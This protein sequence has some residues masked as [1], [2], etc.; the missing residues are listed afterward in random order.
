MANSLTA[1]SPDY[2]S[3]RMQIVRIKEP[4][5]KAIANT[6]ERASLKNGDVVHRPYRSALNVQT[7]TKGTAVTVQDLT[8]TDESLTVGTAKIVPFYV[9]DL[10]Q[11]QNKWDTVNAFADDAGRELEA[12]I[13]GDFLA[14]VAN[15]TGTVT[16]GDLGG[17]AGTAIVLS[18]S[19]V[20]KVFAAAGKKLTNQLKG[21]KMGMTDRFAVIT[22]TVHQ[23]LVEYLAGKDTNLADTIGQNGKIGSFLGF[24]LYLSVNTYYTARWTPADMPSDGDT[25]TIN[26]VVLTFETGTVDTAGKVKSETSTA[27]TLDNLVTALSAPGTSVSG[28]Y[29][30]VSAAN[31]KLLQGLTITDGT[32]YVD[33]AVEGGG[34]I[35]VAA[36][37]AA[38]L[39]SLTKAHLMFGKKKC[40][41]IVVQK[42]PSVVFKEVPDKLGKNVLPWTLYGLKTFTEG[43]QMMVD[44]V[45]DASQF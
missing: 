30:A 43:A 35:A 14:E 20:L 5:Y 17:T 6:E 13:D 39:W 11:L 31:Q 42:E 32:T 4:V 26:G 36:S 9:D 12:F 28:V 2:W 7:Y 34:E 15:A 16:D 44:V 37:S 8:A 27:V 38:D 10:D 41:D 45:L 24:E 18:T 23:I 33:I 3:K 19:N 40:V 22:P 1:F 25:I 29:S 21:G